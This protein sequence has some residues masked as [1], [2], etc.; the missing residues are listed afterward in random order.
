ML[1]FSTKWV[2]FSVVI[3]K[4]HLDLTSTINKVDLIKIHGKDKIPLLFENIQLQT[5][6]LK[7]YI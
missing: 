2:I 6:Q 3:Q 1:V 4:A 7:S 5:M